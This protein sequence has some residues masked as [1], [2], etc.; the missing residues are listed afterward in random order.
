MATPVKKSKL[1]RKF[2]TLVGGFTLFVGLVLGGIAYYQISGAP[3][4]NIRLGDE[5]IVAAKA[6]EAAGNAE[7]AYKKFQEAISRYGRAVSKKPNSLE[8]NQKIL[9]T[10]ALMTPKTSGDAQELYQRRETLLR[11]R[12]RSAPLDGAEWMRL[13]ESLKERAELF[14]QS[15][16]WVEVSKVATEA[17]ERVPPTAPEVPSIRALGIQGILRQGGL[18]SQSERAAGEEAARAY[19]KEFPTDAVVWSQLLWSISDDAGRLATA[20]RTREAAARTADFDKA[21]AQARAAL[22][23]NVEISVAELAHMVELRRARDPSATPSAIAA[24]ADKLLWKSGDR[25]SPEFGLAGTLRG[26]A[27]QGFVGIIGT[28]DEPEMSARAIEILQAHVARDPASMLELGALGRLQRHAGQFD[29]ARKSFEQLLALPQPKVSMLAAYSDEVKVSAIEQIFE[30]DFAQW[31]SAQNQAERDAAL[32]RVKADRDRIA[33]I[34][35]GREGEVALIRADAKLAFAQRDYLTAVTKLEEVFIRQKNVAA[36][37]YLIAAI[38][39]LERGEPGAALLKIERALEE[40]PRVGQFMLVR[41]RIQAQLG[42]VSDAKRTVATMLER[43]PTN[44]AALEL[45]AALNKVVGDG[46]INLSDPVIKILGDAELVANEGDLEEALSQ[47]RN[48]REQFPDD[49]RLQRTL[50]QWLLFKGDSSQAN[51]LVGEFL[52]QYPTDEALKR[53]QVISGAGTA[54]GRVTA[55]VDLS[56]RSAA[57]KS[58]DLALALLN[59]RDNLK[60]RLAVAAPADVALLTTDIAEAETASKAAVAKALELAPGDPSLLDRLF[61]EALIAKDDAK[62]AQVIEL[63]EKHSTDRAVQLLLRGRAAAEK[64]DFKKAIEYFEQAQELPSAG[65]IGYRLLGYARERAGD[66]PGAEEAYS[67]SYERR[68]NDII[69]IQLYS[70][71]LVRHGK[72][73]RA[74]EVLRSAALA[75]PQSA[76]VRSAYLELEAMFGSKADS[77]LERRRMYAIRPADAANARQLLRLLIE[78]PPSRDLIFNNDGSSTFSPKEWEAM[79]RERQAQELEL[80][81]RTHMAEA[82]TI[83]DRLMKMDASDRATTR[84]YGSAMQ[85]TGRGAEAVAALKLVAEQAKGTRAWATWLD[86]GELQLETGKPDDATASFAR[87]LELAGAESSQAA[88]LVAQQWSDRHQ[89]KRAIEVLRAQFAT[90]PTIEVARQLAAL[91]TEVRDFAAAREAVAKLASLSV[92]A[93]TFSDRLLSADIANA[94]L[95]ESFSIFT[96][97]E[98]AAKIAEFSKAIEEAIRLDSSSGLPFIVRAGSLQ[99]RFQRTGDVELLKQAKAD[100][101]RGIELQGNYWPATR[102]LASIQMEEGDLGAATQ[103]VRLYTAQN[104]RLA[105]ARRSLVGYLLAAGDNTGAVAAVQ[106]ALAAEPRNP[107]WW[108]ALAE[109]HVAAGKVLDAAADYDQIFAIAKD[110]NVLIKSVVLRATATPPDFNGILAALRSAVDLTNSVPFLQMVGAAAIA[111]SADSDRQK[112]QGLVQLR[113]MYKLVGASNGELTDP[114]MLSVSTLFPYE[115]TAELE[116]F[117]IES[118]ADKPD[119]ALCRSLAQ[120]YLESGPAGTAK[121]REYATRALTLGTN[122]ADKFNALRV[123]GGIEYKSGNFAAAAD[124]FERALALMP[125]DMAALNN[126]AYIEARDLN[127]TASAIARARKALVDYPASTDLMDTLGYALMKAG[128][129]PEAIALLHRASRMQPSAMVFSHL[130]AAQLAAGRPTDAAAALK[131][132]KALP[133]DPEAA[134]ELAAVEKQLASSPR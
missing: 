48:A 44:A 124:A 119:S 37:L 130:A 66:V 78:T 8:Y 25:N 121:A 103:T 1:N 38:S 61:S 51:K 133:V 3:E 115:K 120:R 123:L 50:V 75:M 65:A 129:Y 77:L 132:A 24:I 53:L 98:T 43:D 52:V 21:L 23:D 16:L 71:L 17:L 11:R 108:Q 72:L 58:V 59:L 87:A 94:E 100:V 76:G 54:V 64:N 126:L 73:D 93:E 97:A 105:D 49:V 86:V 125:T 84:L 111:G 13:L 117:V 79:G 31:E 67:R 127:K 131:R 81:A 110:Q 109:A 85:R 12:T 114:W 29:G 7:E 41:A 134:A 18:L 69:T 36:E 47:I 92:G 45:M 122:D 62:I 56:D 30:L 74:R 95:E 116:K 60:K 6:A 14:D 9:D 106:D 35:Q 57:D 5:L 82:A 107:M 39:L 101:L 104:P 4:R 26:E 40:H 99:R 32:V 80:L 90:T 70:A 83:Y 20:N 27:L 15:E 102:L 55:F 89:P 28:I 96:P 63:A 22:P 19:L 10:L 113:D 91:C 46:A 88:L 118:C 128:E 68:P 34:I 42:R 33:T 112:T 2:L